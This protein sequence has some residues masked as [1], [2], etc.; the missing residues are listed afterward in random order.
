MSFYYTPFKRKET[1]FNTR[2]IPLNLGRYRVNLGHSNK[3]LYFVPL[4]IHTLPVLRF[5]HE[6]QET[7][8]LVRQS[9]CRWVHWLLLRNMHYDNCQNSPFAL[10]PHFTS[11]ILQRRRTPKLLPPPPKTNLGDHFT[12]SPSISKGNWSTLLPSLEETGRVTLKNTKIFPVTLT[13]THGI[14]LGH[15]KSPFKLVWVAEQGSG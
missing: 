6:N 3:L 15:E 5:P 12:L 1:P 14:E 9:T 7:D 10:F 11:T 2:N 13:H 8:W 4:S